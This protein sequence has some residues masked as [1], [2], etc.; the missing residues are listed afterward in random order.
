MDRE[1]A[2]TFARRLDRLADFMETVD[3]R[4][5][6]MDYWCGRLDLKALR[7]QAAGLGASLDDLLDAGVQGVT[8]DLFADTES[9]PGS[10]CGTVGCLAGWGATDPVLQDEG[11]GL[12]DGVVEYGGFFG[13]SACEEFFGTVVPF[14]P[15]TYRRVPRRGV[16]DRAIAELRE[17]A[18]R[19]REV[20]SD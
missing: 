15:Q 13:F 14:N 12:H 19:F 7:A 1:K 16:R 20:A 18:R 2:L 11:W 4:R 10:G 6:F 8:G 9:H 5:I 17:E 3:P